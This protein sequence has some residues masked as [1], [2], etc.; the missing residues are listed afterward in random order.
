MASR[1]GF[2]DF[3]SRSWFTLTVAALLLLAV[4]GAILFAL[5]LLGAETNVNAWLR[6]RL[7]LTYH[8]PLAWWFCLLLLLVPLAIV[9]LYFLKLKRKPLSVPSTFLWRK[10]IEDLHVNA[11]FQWLRENVLL[12][13]QVLAVLILI[14]AFLDF[15]VHGRTSTGKH[16]ILMIDNSASMSATDVTPS[17]LEWAKQE[18][19][20]E[21]D[22]ATDSDFG[23]V[24]V[25][26]ST[27]EIRQSYTNNRGALRLA[28]QDV[29]QTQRPTR[30]EEALSL[31]DSLANPARSTDDAS[32][33]PA[34]VEPGKERT[35]VAAEGVPTEIHLFSDGRFADL[36]EFALGNLNIQFHAAG[37]Q[38]PEN[39]NNVGLV[40]LSAQRD[41][42]DPTKL[43]VFARVV[44]FCPKRVNAEVQ[45]DVRIDDQVKG[46]YQKDVALPARQVTEEKVVGREEPIVRDSPGEGSVT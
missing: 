34:G 28:V 13:L 33:R 44:N 17:R 43:Q 38:G 10:S 45:L 11:L 2:K 6:E 42:Q 5:N 7:Q 41:E 21:I 32:V 29:Q 31:A 27:A 36:P 16:Y 1:S 26:N 9:L 30:I 37:K 15:R 18:A 8:I 22:A 3:L 46:V 24:I 12:L 23:M 19:L 20:K 35:Y 14:Y 40:R 39:V 25:F 4:P